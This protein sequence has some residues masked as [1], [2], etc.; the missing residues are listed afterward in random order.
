MG[1]SY[2]KKKFKIVMEERTVVNSFLIPLLHMLAVIPSVRLILTPLLRF[3]NLVP[4]WYFK[5]RFLC[6]KILAQL[7]NAYYFTLGTV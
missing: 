7:L 6:K 2:A 3:T 5:A 4:L 1:S